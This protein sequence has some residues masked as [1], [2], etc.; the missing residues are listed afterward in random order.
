MNTKERSTSHR[1]GFT[2]IE[3][4]IVVVILGILAAITAPLVGGAAQDA[5]ESSARAQLQAVRK[6]IE[7][8][9]MRN[10]GVAPPEDG[11][12]GLDGLWGALMLDP[13]TRPSFNRIPELPRDFEFSWQAS[14]LNLNYLGDD[15]ALKEEVPLW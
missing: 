12:N 2:L 7:L 9:R 10:D 14:Q 6:Q 11:A 4:L 3:I 13:S 1:R 8:Y 15:S 5:Q